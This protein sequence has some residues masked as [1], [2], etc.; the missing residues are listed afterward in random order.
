MTPKPNMTIKEF[1]RKLGVST[2]TVSRAFSNKGRISAR[3]RQ[4]ILEQAA[5]HNYHANIHA[6]NLSRRDA[7]GITFFFPI[8]TDDEPDYFMHEIMTGINSSLHKIGKGLQIAPFDIESER[9]IEECKNKILD[10]S[11]A[12]VFIIGGTSGA[13]EL[14]ATAEKRKVPFINIGR[15]NN[16]LRNSVVFDPGQGAFLAG[17]YFRDTRRR[18][19]AFVGSVEDQI[20][21][22]GFVKGLAMPAEEVAY[23]PGGVGFTRGAQ[24][25]GWL[26]EHYPETDAVLCAN[27]VLAI[28][29]VKAAELGGIEIPG[30]IA[31]IGFD[32]LRFSRHFTPSLS[33]VSLNLVK[34]GTTAVA[35]MERLLSGNGEPLSNEII[36]C[37]L[38]LRESS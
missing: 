23:A 29:L 13:A 35:M 4:Y 20:K 24:A 31:V 18:H 22:E 6:R 21:F 11:S 25:L 37:D 36:E 17:K 3:T 12:G 9:D 33:S 30:K 26:M 34:I 14:A 38:V 16:D 2:A 1:S 8:L 15:I 32:D 10:G 19:P 27:D 28:G 7:G 5:I